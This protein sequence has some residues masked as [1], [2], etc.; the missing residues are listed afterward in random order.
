MQSRHGGSTSEATGPHGLAPWHGFTL[1]ELLV[2]IAILAVLAGI[3]I[4]A[5]QSARESARRTQCSNNLRQTGIAVNLFAGAVGRLPASG[6]GTDFSVSPP[7]TVS[8]MHSLFTVLLPY[9]EEQALYDSIDRNIPYHASPENL[10]ATSKV[11]TTFLC[12]SESWRGATADEEG[13]GYTDYGSTAFVDLDP[14]TGRPNHAT[15]ACGA[16]T[17]VRLPVARISDGLSHTIAVAEDAGRHGIMPIQE[18]EP[19]TG[20]PRKFWRW[21]EPAS[22][23]GVSWPVNAH[24]TPRGGPADCAWLTTDCGP[25]QEIFGFHVGGAYAV[26]CDT[27]VRFL[28]DST[29]PRVLR[30]LVTRAASD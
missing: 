11:V 7:A 20:N 9:L 15:R 21:V 14:V 28:D 23:F 3:L 19:L 10:M 12:P 5:V 13:F 16:L 27:H 4:P 25:N 18:T 2:V 6:R 30:A 24:A 8:S 17:H 1:I 22:S 26:F 29:E